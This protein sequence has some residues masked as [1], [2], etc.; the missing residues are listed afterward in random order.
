MKGLGMFIPW[1]MAAMAAGP[2]A[3]AAEAPP[4]RPV[5]LA[6][7]IESVDRSFP[8]V[9]AAMAERE[10]AVASTR[11]ASGGFDPNVRASATLEPVS[12]YPKQWG[13]VTVEQPTPL[14]GTTVFGGY[15][16]GLGDYAVYDGKLATNDRGEVRAGARVPLLRDGPTDRRRTGIKTADLGLEM[17]NLAL[18]QQRIDA[19]RQAA[20]RYWDWVAA[21]ARR[22]VIRDW[23]QLARERDAGLATRVASGDVPEIERQ[24]N[25]RTILQR[26]GALAAAERDVTQA[27]VEL[28]L[29][30]RDR[31][32]KPHPPT[33]SEGPPVL[34][35]PQEVTSSIVPDT[36]V[37][38]ARR[39]DVRRLDLAR[40][41]AALE[42]TLAD[43]Q[44]LPAVDL[45]GA[46]SQDLGAGD[47]K[48]GKPVLEVTLLLDIPTLNRVARGRA[49][50]AE[51][52]LRRADEQL[53]L[54]RDRVVADVRNALA[55]L[56]AA[57]V[58]AVATSGEL[59]V[60]RD[61]ARAE[62]Q[63]FTLGESTLLLVN[64]REQASAEAHV[65]HIDVVADFH[66]SLASLRAAMARNGALD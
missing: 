50:A 61:L 15:R 44:K 11:I 43:N 66:R 19:R 22:D 17:A 49:E 57:R 29:F 8:L 3:G 56:E 60:A 27:A 51:A 63:R 10:E 37:A 20:F 28:S 6:E 23:L 52:I 38:L 26:E 46:G 25:R 54:A 1:F 53:R 2:T 42:Q 34:V 12:G 41:R 45:I 5:T 59:T 33:A 64:L 39:P 24:E 21:C 35:E 55:G 48:R 16:I 36:D 9:R 47:P 40:R 58:R 7:V 4:G 32:G 18:E 30:L 31:E 65:R 14:W 62:L 13:Q